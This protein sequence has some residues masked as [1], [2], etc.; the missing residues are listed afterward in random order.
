MEKKSEN[1]IFFQVSISTLVQPH[2]NL[3]QESHT[4]SSADRV[5]QS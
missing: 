4:M 1:V 5:K 2:G 3:E